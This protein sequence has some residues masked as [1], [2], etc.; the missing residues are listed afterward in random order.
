[1]VTRHIVDHISRNTRKDGRS[2]KEAMKY[3]TGQHEYENSEGERQ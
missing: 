3:C 2:V 1:V